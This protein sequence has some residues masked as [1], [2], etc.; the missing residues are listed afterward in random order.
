MTGVHIRRRFA[1]APEAVFDAWLDPAVAR[2]W[3]FAGPA[4]ELIGVEI[5]ARVGGRY[6][7]LERHP[8]GEIDHFG[9]YLELDRPRRLAF[10]LQVPWHFPEVTRVELDIAARENGGCELALAQ[11]GIDPAVTERFWVAMLDALAGIVE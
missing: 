2:R 5:D 10:T 1:A 6:S 4:S 8:D 9:T 11:L 3:L 7:L